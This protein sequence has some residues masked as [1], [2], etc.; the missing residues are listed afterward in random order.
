MREVGGSLGDDVAFHGEGE[1]GEVGVADDRAELALGCEHA[2]G[3]PPEAHVAVLPA[4][5]VAAGA[6]DGLD[7]GSA[8]SRRAA[9]ARG[10]LLAA[11]LRIGSGPGSPWPLPHHPACGS[12][13]GGSLSVPGID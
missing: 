6:A 10:G 4:L 1:L 12:A 5:D 7:V 13:P 8:A 9:L 3:R 2:G 11:A